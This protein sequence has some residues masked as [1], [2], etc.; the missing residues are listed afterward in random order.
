MKTAMTYELIG[1][2]GEVFGYAV[3]AA[4]AAQAACRPGESFAELPNPVEFDENESGLRTDAATGAR[5]AG[6]PFVAIW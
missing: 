3:D 2:D 4:S 6:R 5:E 1:V